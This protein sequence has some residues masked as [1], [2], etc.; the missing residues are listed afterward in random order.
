MRLFTLIF[1][2]FSRCF[3]LAHAQTAEQKFKN[4]QIFKRLPAD[5]AGPDDGFHLRLARRP[6]QL[7]PRPQQLR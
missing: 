4:I 5:A 1:Y 6:L 2:S 7:L 3:Q